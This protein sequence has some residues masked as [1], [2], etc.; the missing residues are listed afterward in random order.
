MKVLDFGLAKVFDPMSATGANS[1]TRHTSATEIGLI[2]GTAAYMSPEQAM[3]KPID[4]RVDVWA[5]GVVLFEMLTGER[6]FRGEDVAGILAAVLKDRPAWDTLPAGTPPSVRR[7]LRRCLEKDRRDRL[8][9]MSAVRLDIKDAL[10]GEPATSPVSVQRSQRLAWTAALVAIALLSGLLAT[11]YF[12]RPAETFEMRLEIRTPSTTDPFSFALSPDGRRVAFVADD[13]GQSRLWVR[14]FD[15]LR[16]EPLV[17][18]EGA[19]FPFWSPDSRSLAFFASGWLK[20]LDIGSGPPR[21]LTAVIAPRGGSWNRD[22]IILF[23]PTVLDPLWRIS[24]AGGAPIPVTTIRGGGE[25]GHLFPQFLPDGHRFLFYVRGNRDDQGI[26]LGSLGSE[27][28]TRLT[29]AETAGAY[30]APG[31]LLFVRNG[32]LVAR[33]FDSSSAQLSGEPVT[34]ADVV[35]FEPVMHAGAFSAARGVVLYRPSGGGIEKRQLT[36]FDRSGNAVGTLGPADDSLLEW[37][38]LSPDGHRVAVSRLKDSNRDVWIFDGIRQSRLTIDPS[39]DVG[40]IWSPDGNWIVFSSNRKGPFN[41]YR[42]RSD[43]VGGDQLL[44]ESPFHKNATGWS[45]EGHLLYSVDNDPKT[46]YDLWSLPLGKA[47]PGTATVT[48][49]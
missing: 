38:A 27:K 33:R 13:A 16:A 43:G 8:G 32:A 7:L 2:L 18:T 19:T 21:S 17:G 25:S 28:V 14:S 4:K 12:R 30:A 35:G 48:P 41:L 20:R 5:F 34:V 3:G 23:A 1:P 36:W 15:A 9:D 37:P 40:P 10:A 42:K 11:L 22:G 46:G 44:L 29:Q 47:T 6:P 31:W 45:P 26:Y 24:E 39:S 49:E